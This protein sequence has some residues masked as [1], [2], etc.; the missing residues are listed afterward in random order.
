MKQMTGWAVSL[1]SSDELAADV[2]TYSPIIPLTLQTAD[3]ASPLDNSNLET[4]ADTKE[5]NLLLT[6]PLDSRNHSLRTTDAET[7]RNDDAPCRQS[8]ADNATGEQN[9][10]GRAQR[11]PG[12]VV[13]NGVVGL[14]LRL[15]VGRVHPL[16]VSI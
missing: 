2:R 10:L 5:W 3:V 13:A 8:R 4:E 12:A 6:R 11:A 9:S 1:D 14:H 15:K 16:D 7:A